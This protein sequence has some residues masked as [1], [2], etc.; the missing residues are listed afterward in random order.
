MDQ[1]ITIKTG[2]LG[3]SSLYIYI[4]IYIHLSLSLSLSPFP[5]I[6]RFHLSISSFSLYKT[7]LSLPISEVSTGVSRSIS[8]S[9]PPL[10]N[11]CSLC[12]SSQA[13]SLHVIPWCGRW[14]PWWSRLS[15]LL[16]LPRRVQQDSVVAGMITELIRFKAEVCICN[17]NRIGIAGRICICNERYSAKISTNLSL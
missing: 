11:S 1:I 7:N 9:C 8:T 5:F 4:Y 6:S 17:G 14:D 12:P 10:S 15:T 13:G 3:S 2:K 16:K